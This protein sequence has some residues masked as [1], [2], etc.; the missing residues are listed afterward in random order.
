MPG[1]NIMVKPDHNNNLTL[2]DGSNIAVVGGGP[3]GSFFAYFALEMA[4]RIGLDINI[5]IIEAKDFN[6][7]GAAGCTGHR[8][9][10]NCGYAL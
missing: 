7:S 2:E 5:D 1:F 8:Q 9:I 3:S 4:N 6:C 10:E